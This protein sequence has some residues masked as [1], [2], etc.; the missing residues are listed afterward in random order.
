MAI[1]RKKRVRK[2]KSWI[3]DIPIGVCIF[4]IAIGIIIGNIFVIV[5]WHEGKLIDKSETI[6]VT[7]TFSSY[8]I[9]T[10]PNGKGAVNEVELCFIDHEKLYID[11][12]CFNIDVETALDNLEKGD[13]LELLLHPVSNYIWDIQRDEEIILSFDDAKSRTRFENIAFTIIGFFVYF[14]AIM[15]AISLFLQWKENMK[16]KR[17]HR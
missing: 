8:T 7:A 10:S 11:G 15:G 17:V 4:F 3:T 5:T 9:H 6:P 14:C 1:K 16:T 2:K 12:A 13:R